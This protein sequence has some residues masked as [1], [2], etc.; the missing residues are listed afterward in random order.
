MTCNFVN[1]AGTIVGAPLDFVATLADPGNVRC[2]CPVVF[3]AEPFTVTIGEQIPA[4]SATVNRT[5]NVVC[6]AG[7]TCPAIAAVPGSGTI[8]LV[9]GGAAGTVTTVTQSGGSAGTTSNVTC[10][11]SGVSAGSTFAVTGVPATLSAGTPS[12]TIAAT[13]ANTAG[14]RAPLR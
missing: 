9:N 8:N 6:G 2:T 3:V 5:F 10:A 14:P 7:L 11:V 1:Q 12:T 4:G 13:C